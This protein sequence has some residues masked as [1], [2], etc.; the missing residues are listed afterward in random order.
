MRN[1]CDTCKF[2]K[3]I[4][5]SVNNA[6]CSQNPITKVITKGNYVQE[7]SCYKNRNIIMNVINFIKRK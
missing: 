5:N 3:W 1:L 6:E 7:C 4:F 2:A